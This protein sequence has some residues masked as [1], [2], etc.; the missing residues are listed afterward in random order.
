MQRKK[1]Q[2]RMRLSMAIN[3]VAYIGYDSFDI[4]LYLSRI[5]Q[6]LGRKVL[7]VDNS[8]TYALTTSVPQMTNINSPDNIITYRRVDFTATVID[9]TMTEVYDDILIDCGFNVPR[10]KLSLVTRTVYVT[11]MFKNSIERLRNLDFFDEF[12]AKKALLI[13]EA[14]N[15]KIS[16]ESMSALLD[17]GISKESITVLFRD[18]KDYDNSLICQYNQTFKLGKITWMMKCYLMKEAQELCGQFT[19]KQI[20]AALYKARKGE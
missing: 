14:V 11:S 19:K 8:D 9:E 7:I 5:L 2:R 18:D 16:P 10:L 17:K 12:P 13:R 1:P 4:I 15:I 3:I 20:R 6:K